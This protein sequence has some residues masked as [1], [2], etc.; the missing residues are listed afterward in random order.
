MPRKA[1][2]FYSAKV[3]P[4]VSITANDCWLGCDHCDGRYLSGMLHVTEPQDLI[5]MAS[6]LEIQGAKGLLISGGCLPD[7]SIPLAPFIDA[8][9]EVK[10]LT[11][12]EINIH[13][14]LLDK[15]TAERLVGTG[16]DCFS[17][18]V[19][20]DP[21][22]IRRLLHLDLEP[23]M[24]ADTLEHLR[25]SGAERVVPHICVGL[26]F[27]TVQGEREALELVSGFDIS[28]L[29]VLGFIPTRGTLA[30]DH[31]HAPSSR[32][33]KF[34]SEARETLSCPILL[35]C[36]RPRHDRTLE[37][38]ALEL[39]VEG[40]AAPSMKTVEWAKNAGY[41]VVLGDKCCALYL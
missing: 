37:W 10:R 38:R 26:P 20:Q 8:I 4:A 39:G 32:I 36:M 3:F 12:L 17:L 23:K 5:R 34:I 18:D 7:G 33:L 13:T 16:T 15:E 41:Q 30:Q 19:I 31:P 9:G 22:V 2:F 21:I 11:D 14:G 25:S 24:Y 29:V 35:G 27:S 28:S 6:D 40:I 1:A